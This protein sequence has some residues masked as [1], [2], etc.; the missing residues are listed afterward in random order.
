VLWT[1][2]RKCLP[3]LPFV[4]SHPPRS[5]HQR[6]L[7]RRVCALK[8]VSEGGV[9]WTS[10][11]CARRCYGRLK[12]PPTP[13]LKVCS[14]GHGERRRKTREEVAVIFTIGHTLRAH[15][16]LGSPYSLSGFLEVV[17]RLVKYGV[18]VGHDRSIGVGILR[19]V[20]EP[21]CP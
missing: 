2:T 7:S 10:E 5:L 1:S 16:A 4:Q 21:G 18:F 3:A 19:R 20:G 13:G 17:H 9:L 8:Q 11:P 6:S 15:E 14:F 12:I